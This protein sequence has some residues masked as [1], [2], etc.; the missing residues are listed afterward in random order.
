M[1]FEWTHEDRYRSNDGKGPMVARILCATATTVKL[2]Q[3][4]EKR[5]DGRRTRFELPLKF[6]CSRKC[7]WAPVTNGEL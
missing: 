7:G 3:W 1:Q 5:P 2:E 4:N 6:F